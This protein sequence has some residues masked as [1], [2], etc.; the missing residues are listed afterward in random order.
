MAQNRP[1][2][3]ILKYIE[4]HVFRISDFDKSHPMAGEVITTGM[5]IPG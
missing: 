2:Q 3:T 5:E 4:P 1:P